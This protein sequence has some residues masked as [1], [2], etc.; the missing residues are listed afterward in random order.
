MKL[1]RLMAS[2]C[3]AAMA[4]GCLTVPALADDEQ[5][6]ST[7]LTASVPSSYTITVPQSVVMIGDTGTGEKTAI[8]KV[9]LKGDIAENQQVTVT[10]VAPTMTRSGSNPVEAEIEAPKL[11]WN[12]DD[13]L[14]NDGEGTKSEYIVE[15]TLTPGDWVGVATFNCSLGE[16]I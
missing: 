13:L 6:V 11:I 2:A 15:A 8:I 14:A 3:T 7:D 10:P 4:F 9:V 12:C 1:K 5:H 16:I